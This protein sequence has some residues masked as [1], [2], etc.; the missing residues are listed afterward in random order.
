VDP[1]RHTQFGAGRLK[2]RDLTS[3]D[4]QECRVGQGDLGETYLVA[5]K[6]ALHTF[7][8]TVHVLTAPSVKRSRRDT[9]QLSSAIAAAAITA[10]SVASDVVAVVA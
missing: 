7:H 8:S 4:H 6:F 9:S 3:R 5:L 1:S 10:D 2:T